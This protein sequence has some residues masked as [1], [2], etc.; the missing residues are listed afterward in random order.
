MATVDGFSMEMNKHNLCKIMKVN[1]VVGHVLVGLHC[2]FNS[3][4]MWHN[5]NLEWNDCLTDHW[6]TYW[7]EMI[8]WRITDELIGMKW[9]FD[10]SLANLLEW[11][12]CLTDHWRTYWNEMIVWR[13]TGELIGM[14]WLFDGSL[15][16]LLEWNDCL[17]DHWRTYWNEMIVW[18]ITG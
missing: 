4:M 3:H 18:R 5:R 17:T 11:N 9:L 14:K 15:A 1:F 16:N 13:I 2:L 8:V 12:D 6:R 10:G 7:N